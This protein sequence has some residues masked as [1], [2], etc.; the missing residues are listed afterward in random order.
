MT[1]LGQGGRAVLLE[2]IAAVEVALLIEVI[3]DR[4]VDGSKLLED[5]HVP[6]FRHRTLSSSEWLMRVFGPVV[7][8]TP[9]L[10][11]PSITDLVHCSA[12]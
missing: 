11:T 4:S 1:P 9:A 7:E 2:D 8:P 12:V 3:V 6:E 10:V 5:L